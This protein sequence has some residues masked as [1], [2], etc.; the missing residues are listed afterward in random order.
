MGLPGR[1]RA[2]GSWFRRFTRRRRSR[3]RLGGGP[4]QPGELNIAVVL[5]AATLGAEVG[6]L[7]GYRIGDRLGRKLVDR[8]GY[9]RGRLG[10]AIDKAEVL[11]AK[12]G[13]V[14]VFFTPTMISGVLKMRYSQFVVWNFFAGALYVFSIGPAAYGAGKV[15][16]GNHDIGSV[17][18]LVAGALLATACVVLAVWY[19]RRRKARR[20]SYTGDQAPGDP[21]GRLRLPGSG[22]RIDWLA[23]RR[24]G[25]RSARR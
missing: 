4:R 7:M 18:A 25:S 23:G 21:R 9:Q 11:Y 3:D 2:D 19:H 10:S 20:L 14:A 1:L 5:L 8:P 16:S 24:G 12:W 6:G 22:R 13:P 15:A 17:G